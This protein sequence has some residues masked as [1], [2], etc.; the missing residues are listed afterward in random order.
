MVFFDSYEHLIGVSLALIASVFSALANV[1]I[2]K[3]HLKVSAIDQ[4][5][6]FVSVFFVR[7]RWLWR[8]SLACVLRIALSCQ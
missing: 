2:K 3:N 1:L 4:M 6:C 8:V 5:F 7:F